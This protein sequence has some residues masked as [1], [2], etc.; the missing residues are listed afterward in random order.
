MKNVIV[1]L[2]MVA[3]VMGVDVKGYVTGDTLSDSL[4]NT[5]IMDSA[6]IVVFDET[7]GGIEGII[8]CGIVS[9]GRVHTIMFTPNG[10]IYTVEEERLASGIMLRYGIKLD[11]RSQNEYSSDYFR[12]TTK[13][14]TEFFMMAEHNSYID[15]P[16]KLQVIFRDTELSK[17]YDSEKSIESSEDF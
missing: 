7:L 11:K 9:D 12:S 16:V 8:M 4:R 3:V 1:V 13:N 10:R 2:A 15:K 5:A 14:G 17:I 6:G